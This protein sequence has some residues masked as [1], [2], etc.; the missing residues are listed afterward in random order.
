MFADIKSPFGI[1]KIEAQGG[2]IV[3]V[4]LPNQEYSPSHFVTAPSKKEPLES[5]P[6]AS[7][8]EGGVNEVDGGSKLLADAKMQ[9]EEYFAGTRKVFDLPLD[10]SGCTEFMT[11]VYQELMRVPYGE[12]ASYKNIAE[13]VASPKAYRAVGLANNKNILPI[14]VPCHRIIGAD[15]GLVGYAGGLDFKKWLLELE[16]VNFIAV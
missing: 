13:R 1:I 3:R 5:K 8:F 2:A 14:I 4:Y 10:F 15:G 7:L 9:F 11:R 6:K 12:T 16:R